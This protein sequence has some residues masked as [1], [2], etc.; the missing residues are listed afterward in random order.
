M[1]QGGAWRIPFSPS[2]GVGDPAGDLAKQ[3][4]TT[5]LEHLAIIGGL[6]LVIVDALRLG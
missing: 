6:L 1:W 2:Q 5:A 3:V 4:F